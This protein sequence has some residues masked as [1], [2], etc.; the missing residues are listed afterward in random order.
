MSDIKVQHGDWVV[1]CDGK[2][3]LVLENAGDAKF[4]DLKTK[5]VH[6]HPDPKT[7]ELGTDAPG[8][9]F[10]SVGTSRSAMEQTDWHYQEEQRFLKKLA[11]RLDAEVIAGNVK[12]LIMVAP[13]RALGVLRQA[14]S[15]HVRHALRAEIEKDF[16]KMPVHEIEKHLAA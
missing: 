1:V 2:K 14:Y 16:V 6:E 10:S 8:R 12:S 11:G 7:H 13:P 4:L 15:Q 9:S 5:E 3:A